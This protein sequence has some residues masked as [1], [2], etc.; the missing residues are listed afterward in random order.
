[1]NMMD[2]NYKAK[3]KILNYSNSNSNSNQDFPL[4]KNIISNQQ[5][6]EMLAGTFNEVVISEEKFDSEKI[7]RIYNDLFY[8]IPKKGKKSHTTIIE[9]STDYVY[10]WVNKNLDDSIEKLSGDISELS[11]LLVAA[12]SPVITPQHPIYE[13]GLLLQ[14]SSDGINPENNNSDIYY[15]QQGLKR[16]IQKTD[17]GYYIRML[18]QANGDIMYNED[19]ITYTPTRESPLFRYV[20]SEDLNTIEDGE[21]IIGGSSLSVDPVK[22]IGFQYVYDE[23][24]LTVKCLGIESFY[25]FDSDEIGYDPDLSEYTHGGKMGG[26]WWLDTN[27]VCKVKVKTDVDPTTNFAGPSQWISIEGGK[28]Q[29]ITFSRDKSFYGHF[30]GDPQT[31]NPLEPSFYDGNHKTMED[32]GLRDGKPIPP[33]MVWKK[34]GDKNPFPAITDI[35]EG[36]RMSYRMKT[37]HKDYGNGNFHPV[38]QGSH[39]LQGIIDGSDSAPTQ[40]VPTQAGVLNSLL[41]SYASTGARMIYGTNY[42]P[43]ANRG[44]GINLITNTELKNLLSSPTNHYY[45]ASHNGYKVYGQPIL[46]VNGHF[47]VF[48]YRERI[49][50]WY[51]Y[52]PPVWVNVDYNVFYSIE[53]GK[54]FSLWNKKLDDYVNGYKRYSDK[55]F[56]WNNKDGYTNGVG[57][58][59][60]QTQTYNKI[61]NPTI[62]FP[63]LQGISL[64]REGT[65][66]DGLDFTGGNPFNPKVGG[67]NYIPYDIFNRLK[68]G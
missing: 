29:D 1:M 6:K 7:K 51:S 39:W 10:P 57:F 36:S 55:M 46:H 66:G 65:E 5:A 23:I 13:N 34:W 11:S 12:E 47:A 35:K 49:T 9:Q 20:T 68:K 8:L 22:N 19:G 59:D 32:P 58:Y 62:Y 15:M 43:L 18:R 30:I 28:S 44:F 42:G 52:V 17:E 45:K 26:Y 60:V 24:K 25:N 14:Q 64:N 67:S 63:G 16:K 41:E 2:H 48:L 38:N 3:K 33:I 56:N 50:E 27:G 21:P 54:H 61:N 53:N 37:P 31:D 4:S 40:G